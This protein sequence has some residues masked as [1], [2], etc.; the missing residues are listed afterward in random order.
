MTPLFEYLRSKKHLSIKYIDDSL[1]LGKTFEIYFNNIRATVALLQELGFTIHPEKSVLLPR[2]QIIF[3]VFVIDSA[4]MA[5]TLSEEKKQCVYAF[6]QNILSNYQARIIEL[7][8]TI[9]VIVSSL[10]VVPYNPMYYRELKK[11]KVESLPRSGG[12]C[13]RKCYISVAAASELKWWI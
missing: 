11:F 2:Q 5:I 4:R 1:L 8:Q 7:A 9:E 13:D 6:Y 10:R 3:L 12:N